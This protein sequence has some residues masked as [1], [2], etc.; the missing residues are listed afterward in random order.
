M[1]AFNAYVA[2]FPYIENPIIA[3][4]RAD[5]LERSDKTLGESIISIG[6]LALSLKIF[7]IILVKTSDWFL[8]LALSRYILD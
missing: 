5:T 2:F 6:S 4:P 7:F 8:A 3:A 1:L